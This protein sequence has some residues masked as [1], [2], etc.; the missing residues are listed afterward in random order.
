MNEINLSNYT[1][2]AP[3]E[4]QKGRKPCTANNPHLP[5]VE[6][7]TLRAPKEERPSALVAQPKVGSETS[8]ATGGETQTPAQTSVP[9]NAQNTKQRVRFQ[10][11][12]DIAP[13]RMQATLRKEAA[14]T[15]GQ[16]SASDE[17][18]NRDDKAQAASREETKATAQAFV[19]FCSKD[20]LTATVLLAGELQ[21]AHLDSCASHCFVSSE[22]S[23]QL[24][25][26]GFPLVRS[27]VCFEVKQGKPLCDTNLVHLLPLTMIREDGTRCTWDNC[28]FLVADA[29]ASIILCYTL[30]RLG[31]ILDYEPPQ[32]YESVLQ[33]CMLD[34][35][36]SSG[37][38][39]QLPTLTAADLRGGPYYQSPALE[40]ANADERQHRGTCLRTDVR[41]ENLKTEGFRV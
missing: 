39:R 33:H 3:A 12:S 13:T 27:P 25:A 20:M 5:G 19:S 32:G 36:V 40:P 31:G 6:T 41:R 24:T 16:L 4:A 7:D 29:G 14:I 30:L 18:C 28:M 38:R 23:S 1:E 15:S 37:S 2:S 8:S 34:H 10:D 26:K 11:A 9:A 35:A 22:L 21:T 17:R